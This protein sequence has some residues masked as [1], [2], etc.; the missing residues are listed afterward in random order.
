[1]KRKTFRYRK[2]TDVLSLAVTLVWVSSNWVKDG[3]VSLVAMWYSTGTINGIKHYDIPRQQ[4]RALFWLFERVALTSRET[5]TRPR[6]S[7]NRF[8]AWRIIAACFRC[9]G[10]SSMNLHIVS[11][12][13]SAT[14]MPSFICFPGKTHWGNRVTFLVR[15]SRTQNGNYS[16]IYKVYYVETSRAILYLYKIFR[17]QK[18]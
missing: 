16:W 13:S 10:T 1:M 6:R 3:R 18:D 11:H 9:T 4:V 15:I 7:G 8:A 14:K 2:V 17:S 12:C 5:E